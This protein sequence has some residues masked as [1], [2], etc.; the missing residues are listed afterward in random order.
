MSA[1]KTAPSAAVTAT[2]DEGLL[3]AILKNWGRANSPEEKEILEEGLEDLLALLPEGES[4]DIDPETLI[5]RALRDLDDGLS[6]QLNLILHDEQFRK[7]ESAWRGLHYMVS[8][9]ATGS[10]LKID[11]VPVSKATVAADAQ[12]ANGDFRQ[13]QLYKR[14]VEQELGAAGGKPVSLF[15]G[16][17][18]F[19][20]GAAD[21][22][23]LKRYLA[24][25]AAA[26]HAPF[27][28]PA[29]PCVF[30]GESLTQRAAM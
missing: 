24:P 10:N 28:T 5:D 21:M 25:M 1:T 29:A 11:L 7:L 18:E 26:A 2:R 3:D 14:L 16:A 4:G 15:L 27:V 8:H 19:D 6:R 23:L 9:A 30:G 12:R 17:F 22:Q 13:G 20:A